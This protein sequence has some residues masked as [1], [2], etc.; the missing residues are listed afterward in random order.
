MDIYKDDQGILWI[1]TIQGGLKRFDPTTEEITHYK[2]DADNPRSINDNTVSSICED[3]YGNLWIGTGHITE[4]DGGGLNKLDRKS[5]RFTHYLHNPADPN[6]LSANR[7]SSMVIDSQNVLWIGTSGGQLNSISIEELLSSE[8]PHFNR[9]LGFPRKFVTS[10]YEDRTGNIWVSLFGRTVHKLDRQ[11]NRFTWFRQVPGDKKSLSSR[12]VQCIFLDNEGNLWC[13]GDDGLDRYNPETK[14]F[15][16]YYHDPDD[17]GSLSANAISGICQDNQGI[18]WIATFNQGIN[19]F[20]PVSHIFRRFYHYPH[21]SSGLKSN[22]IRTIVNTRSGNLWLATYNAGLLRF[23]PEK[24]Q[25]YSYD[26]KP[27]SK[28]DERITYI[29][30]DHEGILWVCTFN[31]GLYGLTIE[32]QQIAKYV[33]Y[34]YDPQNQNSLSNNLVADVIRSTVGDSSILWIATGIGLNRLDLNTNTFTHFFKNGGLSDNMVLKVLEDHNGNIWFT[35][36]AG[37]DMLNIKTNAVK[38]YDEEDG[39]P[40]T[41]FGGSRTNTAKSAD[42]RLYFGG[43]FG[44]ISFYPQEIKTNRNIPP[45]RLTDFKIFNESVELDTAIQFK[46]ELTLSH[47]QNMFSLEFAALDF[48]NPS[49]NQYAYQVVGLH[50]GW[51]KLGHQTSVGFTDLDPGEYIYKVRGSNNHGIWNE[52]GASI[53]III[54]PPFWKTAWFRILTGML[55]LVALILTVR[56]F[57]IRK[58][59]LRLQEMEYQRKL[60]GERERISEDMHDEVGSSLTRIAILSELAKKG[61]PADSEGKEHIDDIS[62]TSRQVVDNIGEIIWAINPQNDSL[63]NLIAYSRQYVAKYFETTSIHCV[64]DFPGK[65]PA[66]S[67]SAEFRRNIFLVIKEAVTNIVKHACA[68]QVLVRISLKTKRMII[69]ITDNGKGF[70]PQ[71]KPRFGNGLENMKNRIEQMGGKW[72]INSAPGEGTKIQVAVNL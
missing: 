61:I 6:S 40:F 12:G 23:D 33:H 69:T 17:C 67:I 35:T 16:H 70:C 24:N 20:D 45:V 63:E 1:G 42:G 30:E 11:Q 65:I 52:E 15:S 48:T 32:E 55:L 7:I 22:L 38:N 53:R 46:R 8:K 39:L 37:L 64:I 43:V 31:D 59:K 62:E 21:S 36:A 58:L 72:E 27:D 44:V 2:Y 66:D 50:D 51:I 19:R 34:A 14:Q 26:I 71:E 41:H 25:C 57:A 49:K 3:K 13:G 60:D 29:Y 9:Y 18:L 4:N 47:N 56:Y 54:D 5:Q 28:D 10:V 68:T